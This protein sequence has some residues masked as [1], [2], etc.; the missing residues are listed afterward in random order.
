MLTGMDPGWGCFFN[1]LQMMMVPLDQK[2]PNIFDNESFYYKK[3]SE[4]YHL[5]VYKSYK[6]NTILKL[7]A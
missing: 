2:S 5:C 7:G 1:K 4:L 6:W 3:Y